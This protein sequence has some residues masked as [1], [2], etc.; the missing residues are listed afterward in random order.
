MGGWIGWLLLDDF[1]MVV[2]VCKYFECVMEVIVFDFLV[3]LIL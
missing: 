1:V 2:L 3:W